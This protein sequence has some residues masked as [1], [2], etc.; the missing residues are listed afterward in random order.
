MDKRYFLIIF[1]IGVC[2]VN[3]YLIANVSDIVGS[4]SVDVGN[5]TISLPNGFSL[6][7]QDSNQVLLSNPDTKMDIQFFSKV[8]HRDTFKN[9]VAEINNDT[10]FKVLSNGTIDN[11]GV[12]VNSLFYQ[13]HDNARNFSIFYF[14][15][16]DH[17][18]RI[19]VRGFDYDSQKDQVIDIV[20]D[21]VTSIRLN[22][23]IQ[24]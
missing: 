22:Y 11:D 9:K 12:L 6:Y 14:T 15:K 7:D 17:D 13:R 21:I 10:Q 20:C 1:I 3:L 23:K 4:A 18:F 16:E 2:V 24:K 19:I 5:Y 8:G